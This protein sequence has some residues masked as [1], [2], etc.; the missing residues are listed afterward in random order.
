MKKNVTLALV[1]V[2][3][4]GLSCVLFSGCAPQK[5]T[6]QD[7]RAIGPSDAKSGQLSDAELQKMRED[8]A[9]QRALREQELRERERREQEAAAARAKGSGLESIYF[10]FDRFDLSAAARATLKKHADWLAKNRAYLMRVEGHCDER[11]TNEYNLALGQ[12]RADA[13]MKYLSGLGVDGKRLTTVSYGEEK[14]EDSGH[15]EQAWAKNRRVS[16]TVSTGKAK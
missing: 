8:E 9:R 6:L 16:F 2:L 14:P 5:R 10:E 15:N 1:L 7:D 12:R 13:A 3:V 11:G 4:F